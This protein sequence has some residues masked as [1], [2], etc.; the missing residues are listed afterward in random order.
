MKDRLLV[1]AASGEMLEGT[2]IF[3]TKLR[4]MDAESRGRSVLGSRSLSQLTSCSR[5]RRREYGAT[6][7]NGMVFLNSSMVPGAA[8]SPA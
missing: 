2:R 4:V 7:A 3:H 6:I 1:V 5:L 8:A